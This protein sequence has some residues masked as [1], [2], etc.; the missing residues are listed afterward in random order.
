V[1]GK[2]YRCGEF[3]HKSNQ[4]PKRKQVN[5][6]DYEEEEFEIEELNDFYFAEEHEKSATYVVQILLCNQ[7]FPDT[8]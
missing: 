6:V 1:V 4:C 7:K 3:G 2:C 8:M 5:I